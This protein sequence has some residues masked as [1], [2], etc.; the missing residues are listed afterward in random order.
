MEN[1]TVSIPINNEQIVGYNDGNPIIFSYLEDCSSESFY[2]STKT[3]YENIKFNT[4]LNK[5]NIKQNI[6]ICAICLEELNNIDETK[7]IITDCNHIFC[8]N[9]IQTHIK[10]SNKC[11]ICNKENF[12][13]KIFEKEIKPTKS[14]EITTLFINNNKWYN[15]NDEIKITPSKAYNILYQ[16][17]KKKAWNKFYKNKIYKNEKITEKRAFLHYNQKCLP[18]TLKDWNSE[19]WNIIIDK[20]CIV[21]MNEE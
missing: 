4:Y 21:N 13:Y 3:F 5:K 14:I 17:F 9:C 10:K 12:T 8:K 19:L 1:N 6:K 2:S 20:E 18:Q 7:L 15:K 16:Y 11:P